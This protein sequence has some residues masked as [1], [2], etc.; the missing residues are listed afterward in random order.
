MVL[1][2]CVTV[3]IYGAVW[4]R[5]W[6]QPNLLL[7]M[8]H[9]ILTYN[10]CVRVLEH[11]FLKYQLGSEKTLEF[12]F[13]TKNN[14]ISNNKSVFNQ[15]IDSTVMVKWSKIKSMTLKMI[16]FDPVYQNIEKRSFQHVCISVSLWFIKDNMQNFPILPCLRN[17]G[18]R[19]AYCQI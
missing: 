12:A 5:V 10:S 2:R 1:V 18:S 14:C 9:Y 4:R 6:M 13:L 19:L 7:G 16:P 11:Y 3:N 15:N 17:V 8:T